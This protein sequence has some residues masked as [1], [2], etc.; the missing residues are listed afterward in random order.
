MTLSVF[1]SQLAPSVSTASSVPLPVS[2]V[3]VAAT[4]N[5]VAAPL[6]YV[7]PGQLNIQIPYQTAVNQ[8]ATLRV[9]NNGLIASY[10]LN[11]VPAA[12]GIFTDSSGGI[13]PVATGNRGSIVSVYL[14]GAGAVNPEVEFIGIPAGLVGVTQINFYVPSSITDGTQPVVV[15]VN[16]QASSAAFLAVAN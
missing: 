1:G 8:P 4:V 11:M 12:P 13:V 14:T 10:Q 5:N 7:S 3:G 6:Y 15:T 16:G 9:N 2:T